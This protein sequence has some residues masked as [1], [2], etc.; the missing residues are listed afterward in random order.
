M[1]RPGPENPGIDMPRYRWRS[2]VV[3]Q[4]NNFAAQERMDDGLFHA[5][6][7]S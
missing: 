7:E 3:F 6:G 1:V 4:Y 2:L 5:S